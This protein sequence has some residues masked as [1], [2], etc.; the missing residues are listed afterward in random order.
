MKTF[1][2]DVRPIHHRNENTTRGHI[3]VTMFA[4][5]I[6]RELENRI[7]PWLKQ[8]NKNAK[9]QLSLQDIEEEFKMIKLN[10]LEINNHHEE[11]KITELTNRQ[12]EIFKELDIK[13]ELLIA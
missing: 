13:P 2:L 8:N 5:A 3:F 10:V 9:E 11:I 6:L 1:N 12:K 7:F 4:Y